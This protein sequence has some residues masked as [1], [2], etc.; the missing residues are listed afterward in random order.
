MKPV[1]GLLLAVLGLAALLWLASWLRKPAPQVA[2]QVSCSDLTVACPV[3][4]AGQALIVRADQA[5]SGLKPFRL[6]VAGGTAPMT[7]RFGMVGMDM[8][9]I[10]VPLQPA[11][12]GRLAAQVVLQLCVQGRRDWHLWLESPQGTIAVSFTASN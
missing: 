12:A 7:A 11:G 4:L 3:I 5:P 10:A 8:G 2:V 1:W 9:P 6:E